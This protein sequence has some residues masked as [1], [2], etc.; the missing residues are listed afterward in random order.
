MC[1]IN[2]VAVVVLVAGYGLVMVMRR[3]LGE[4][5][6]GRWDVVVLALIILLAIDYQI[7]PEL[8][9]RTSAI[10]PL[11]AFLL[12]YVYRFVVVC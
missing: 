8:L 9:H 10:R 11:E 7:N 3:V 2:P 6:V 12:H 5:I 1:H 4:P